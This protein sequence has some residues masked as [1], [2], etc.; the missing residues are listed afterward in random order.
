MD[1]GALRQDCFV[2]HT[3]RFR[4][5]RYDEQ[6]KRAHLFVFQTVDALTKKAL[7]DRPQK[8]EGERSPRLG[9]V[10]LAQL[11]HAH[12]CQIDRLTVRKLDAKRLVEVRPKI[13]TV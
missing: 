6:F 5:N 3:T 10:S 13:G 1:C 8:D 4:A 2:T 11:R 12:Q 7:A 9:F